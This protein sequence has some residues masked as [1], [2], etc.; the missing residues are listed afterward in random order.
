MGSWVNW[1][2]CVKSS[3]DSFEIIPL[4]DIS[5]YNSLVNDLVSIHMDVLDGGIQTSLG[6]D[7]I[8]NL[9]ENILKQYK[10]GLVAVDRSLHVIGYVFGTDDTFKNP[11]QNQSSL[12][13]R[14]LFLV[15]TNSQFRKKVIFILKIKLLVRNFKV[16]FHD[17][18]SIELS[19]FA[20]DRDFQSMGLGGK[21]I[22]A[23]EVL[24]S[25][26]GYEVIFTRT[27]NP[28]LASYYMRAKNANLEAKEQWLGQFSALLSWGINNE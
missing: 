25:K 24:A 7:Y 16:P 13:I 15:L 2:N 10:V 11:V 1:S 6:K 3:S 23:F 17:R 22:R 26:Q 5:E 9:Y 28:R 18:R 12:V 14:S 8:I 19:Y 20:V 21:L 4:S 27:H